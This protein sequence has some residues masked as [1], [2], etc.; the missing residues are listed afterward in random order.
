MNKGGG[1]GTCTPSLVCEEGY[2]LT[3]T[4][5][6]AFTAGLPDVRCRYARIG[7]HTQHV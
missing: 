7:A 4:H 5:F 1:G 6:S 2:K 3:H